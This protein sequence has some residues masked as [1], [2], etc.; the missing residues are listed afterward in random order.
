[1]EVTGNSP[2]INKNEALNIRKL[3]HLALIKVELINFDD[4]TNSK[5]RISAPTIIKSSVTFPFN[6]EAY[7]RNA[8]QQV[9]CSGM[10]TTSPGGWH[11][12]LQH[13][14]EANADVNEWL[15]LLLDPLIT[16]TEKREKSLNLEFKLVRS[17]HTTARQ[18]CNYAGPNAKPFNS[19]LKLQR[20]GKASPFDMKSIDVKDSD[21][22]RFPDFAPLL[23]VNSDSFNDMKTMMKLKVL[24]SDTPIDSKTKKE[25]DNYPI[26]AFRGNIV[27][28]TEDKP[29]EEEK[30]KSL[31]I[32][33][34]SFRLWKGC[35]RCAV[36]ARN[37]GTGNWIIS[38]VKNR[39]LFMATLRKKFPEK[40]IDKE[41]KDRWQGKLLE[42]SRRT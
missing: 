10:S 39:L 15:T 11:L 2:N 37:P 21:Y 41:W 31:S 22:V 33:S 24:E 42:Q 12:G 7:N 8:I 40:C 25:I 23:I 36:P 3:L 29:W 1:M 26:K 14:R 32:G 28:K 30:W 38:E 13:G 27:V 18:V 16:K 20:V 5:L 19:D 9:E 4:K 35:P 17:N 34:T 6:E